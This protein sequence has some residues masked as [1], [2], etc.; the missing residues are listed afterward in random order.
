MSKRNFNF[1]DENLFNWID[2][3][4][5]INYIKSRKRLSPQRLK[6]LLKKNIMK[7]CG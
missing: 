2:L 3:F 6:E 7:S 1:T 4:V 5:D